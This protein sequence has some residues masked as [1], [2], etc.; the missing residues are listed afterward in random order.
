MASKTLENLAGEKVRQFSVFME[1]KAGRLLEIVRLFGEHRVHVVALT[2]LD[3]AD[4]AVVRMVVDDPDRARAIFQEHSLAFTECNLV[5]VELPSSASDLRGVLSAL[6]Q[7]EVNVHFSYSFLTRPRGKAA[8]ALHVDDEEVAT[9]V[10]VQ[11]QFKLLTQK[12]I[13]R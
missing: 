5:V 12:D 11:N 4:A 9:S 1:N 3:T 7:A 6:L 8:L 13:S 10:L 2:I